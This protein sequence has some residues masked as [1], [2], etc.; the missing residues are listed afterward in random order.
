VLTPHSAGVAPEVVIDAHRMAARSVIDA[1]HGVRPS[2][3][4]N[5]D[6]WPRYLQRLDRA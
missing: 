5:P 2:T 4:V 6:V 1:V 3:L